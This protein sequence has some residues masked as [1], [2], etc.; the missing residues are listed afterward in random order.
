MLVIY[1]LLSTLFVFSVV[2][3]L[4]GITGWFPPVLCVGGGPTWPVDKLLFF[5]GLRGGSAGAKALV[6]VDVP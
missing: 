5:C 2:G 3:G 1:Y 4:R 6:S